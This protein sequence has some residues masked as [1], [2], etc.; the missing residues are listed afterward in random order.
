MARK[1]T[2]TLVDDFDGKAADETVTF[3]IDGV[4]YEI[5]LT[6]RNANKLR[7]ELKA[8]VAAGRRVGG[9]RSSSAP[10]RRGSSVNREQ[11]AAIRVWGRRNGFHKAP[12][13]APAV[14]A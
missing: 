14:A 8:W 4:N 10:S 5:D 12:Y 11:T 13:R 6:T 7:G 9:R 3:S 2:V 1:T